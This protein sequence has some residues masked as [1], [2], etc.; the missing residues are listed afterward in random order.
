[1][2]DLSGQYGGDEG[3]SR[4][5]S[6]E[7]TGVGEWCAPGP[8]EQQ[9]RKW[10]LWFEDKDRSVSIFDNEADGRAAF[11]LAESHGWNCHLLAHVPRQATPNRY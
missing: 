3:F 4:Q 6:P 1:M 11:A 10:V 7:E 5:R 8:A 2:A 9:E